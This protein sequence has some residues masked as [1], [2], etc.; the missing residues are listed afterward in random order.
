[1]GYK[2]TRWEHNLG[3][4]HTQ[5]C[6]WPGGAID[7]CYA[8]E[9]GCALGPAPT[10]GGTVMSYCHLTGYGINLANGFGPLPGQKIRNIIRNNP[11]LNPSIYFESISQTVNEES[12]DVENGCFDYKTT[13]G[14]IK[15]TLCTFPTS[16][17]NTYTHGKCRFGDRLH[18]RCRNKSAQFYF[19]C[20]QLN[21]DNKF[22]K[23]IT[24]PLLKY[25][26]RLPLIL[27]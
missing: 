26:K 15:N 3:S 21:T 12:A 13:N 24:M 18:R 9:G 7:N 5:S 14:K 11:C 20:R 1:M 23:C 8:T 25:R 16:K 4:P 19:G 27:I 17:R 2:R 10:N 6:T 22:L